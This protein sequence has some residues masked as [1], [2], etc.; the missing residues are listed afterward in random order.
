M[1]LTYIFRDR[2]EA[3]RAL[4]PLLRA[5]AGRPGVVV[6]GVG[7]GGL[8]VAGEVAGALDAPLDLLSI[9]RILMPGHSA[10]SIGAVASN[11]ACILDTA[12]INASGLPLALVQAARA[13]AERALGIR[14]SRYRN[15]RPSLELNGRVVILVDDGMATGGTMRTAA[16]AVRTRRPHQV[17]VASPVASES[18][19]S[20]LRDIAD[21]CV[22]LASPMP[23][24]NTA[25]W[26][27]QFESPDDATV[28]WLLSGPRATPAAEPRLAQV[29]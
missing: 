12:R 5:Y 11:G 10:I 29:M 13:E 2:R 24:G 23:V 17:I 27:Q 19:V 4:V 9:G 6:V 7:R 1:G 26:Y 18:A 20:A 14:D 22:Y 28:S 8:T 15:G 25:F 21:Q 3:G 16:Q